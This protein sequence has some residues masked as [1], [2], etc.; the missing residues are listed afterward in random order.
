MILLAC[1]VKLNV[2]NLTCRI[3]QVGYLKWKFRKA[4]TSDFMPNGQTLNKSLLLS[5]KLR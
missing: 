3:I 5:P 2:K 1:K 4:K